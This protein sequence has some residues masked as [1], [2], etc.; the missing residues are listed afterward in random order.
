MSAAAVGARGAVEKRR[1]A[2]R[3]SAPRDAR[4]C[5]IRRHQEGYVGGVGACRNR[6]LGTLGSSPRLEKAACIL[7]ERAVAAGEIRT[8]IDPEI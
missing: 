6:F 2:G 7:L 5:R 4:D 3:G 8:G 1:F